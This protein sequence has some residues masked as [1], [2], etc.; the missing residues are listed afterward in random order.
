MGA[1]SCVTAICLGRQR[2]D[3]GVDGGAG[4]GSTRSDRSEGR[5]S[6]YIGSREAVHHANCGQLYDQQLDRRA[7]RK[8]RNFTCYVRNNSSKD[9]PRSSHFPDKARCRINRSRTGLFR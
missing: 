2:P 9:R 6:S 8:R 7:A 3:R 1:D 4:A 5:T